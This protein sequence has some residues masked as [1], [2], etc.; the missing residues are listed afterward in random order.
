MAL[1]LVN[2]FSSLARAQQVRTL[3]EYDPQPPV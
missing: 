2:R 1:Y 3:V